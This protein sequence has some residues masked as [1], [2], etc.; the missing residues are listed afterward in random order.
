MY[1]RK[2]KEEERPVNKSYLGGKPI[3]VEDIIVSCNDEIT[4]R[5]STFA[6]N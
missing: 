4:E 3:I 6:R 1:G 5:Q 2:E